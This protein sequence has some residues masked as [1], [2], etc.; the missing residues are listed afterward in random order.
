MAEKSER[1][2]LLV[3]P[4]AKALGR[5]PK[6]KAER[7][8]EILK[9]VYEDSLCALEFNEGDSKNTPYRL[10]VMSRLS[11][12]CTDKR[13]NIVSKELFKEYPDVFSMAEAPLEDIERIVRPCGLYKTK[14]KSIKDA[15]VII[16]REYGGVVPC[17]YDD[18]I[19]LPGIGMKI[20]NL[21]MGELYD[22]PRIVPD[23]HCMR[24]SHRLGLTSVPDDPV[25][26][27]RELS[28]IVEKK[29]QSD[30]CHRLVFFGR[31][32]CSAQGPRCGDCPIS[33]FASGDKGVNGDETAKNK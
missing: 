26:C 4:Y 24:I 27:E 8:S 29:E 5:T 18:L 9:N 20:A 6:K 28:A 25:K 23:T 19:N 31:E 32:F 22:D 7:V 16:C 14:A 1:K 21:I 11:A 10:L 30:F 12:Q 17:T 2:K 15:C 3:C 33:S 13:V